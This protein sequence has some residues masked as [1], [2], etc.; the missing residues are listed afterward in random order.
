MLILQNRNRLQLLGEVEDDL[1]TGQ[2]FVHR[3]VSVQFVLN[4]GLLV[5]VKLNLKI[6]LYRSKKKGRNL[7]KSRSIESDS[8]SSADDLSGEAKIFKD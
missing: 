1:L 2:L 4:F 5:L 8:G 7:V 6:S 3:S